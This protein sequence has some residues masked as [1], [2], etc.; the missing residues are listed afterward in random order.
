MIEKGSWNHVGHLWDKGKKHGCVGQLNCPVCVCSGMCCRCAHAKPLPWTSGWRDTE[1]YIYMETEKNVYF[2]HCCF[3]YMWREMNQERT[4]HACVLIK[5]DL[6]GG[7]NA[8]LWTQLRTDRKKITEHLQSPP[9]FSVFHQAA[10]QT[11]QNLVLKSWQKLWKG[12]GRRE[13]RRSRSVCS[14]VGRTQA[15]FE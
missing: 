7:V 2:K 13:E 10:S 15:A 12:K 9:P 4:E 11:I 14:R 1:T 6:A 5:R 3:I 8:A